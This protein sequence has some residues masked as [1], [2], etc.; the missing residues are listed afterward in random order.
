MTAPAAVLSG[1][2]RRLRDAGTPEAH[3]ARLRA[4]VGLDIGGREPSEIALSIVAEMVAVE[5]GR[6][7]LRRR[8][9][10]RAE[11]AAAS[12]THLREA[13][14]AVSA[15]FRRDPAAGELPQLRDGSR[16]PVAGRIRRGHGERSRHP[17]RLAH[18]AAAAIIVLMI[19]LLL[20]NS[21]A[22]GLRQH[23]S[24]KARW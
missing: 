13:I 3:I 8:P 20:M 5:H 14:H 1:A 9:V 22:I 24:K 4:P 7:A 15:D 19:V 12:G 10:Q 17:R 6:L 11:H 23:F 18:L 21:I 2:V 16:R